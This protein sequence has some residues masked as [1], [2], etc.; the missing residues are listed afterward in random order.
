MLCR[1]F[2]PP[3]IVKGASPKFE[4]HNKVYFFAI[5]KEKRFDCW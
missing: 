4:N 5:G 2:S 1:T 3:K